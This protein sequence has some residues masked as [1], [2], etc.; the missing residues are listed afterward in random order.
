MEIIPP[1]TVTDAIFYSSSISEPSGFDIA[2]DHY[3]GEWSAGTNYAVDDMVMVVADHRLY[4]SLITPNEGFTPGGTGNDAY[5]LIFGATEAWLPFDKQVTGQAEAVGGADIVYRFTPGMSIDSVVLLNI[6]AE[7]VMVERRHGT[8]A[9]DVADETWNADTYDEVNE[10]Y[11]SDIVKTDFGA[12]NNPY[13]TITIRNHLTAAKVGEIVIGNK[14]SIG[15]TLYTPT[16]GIIDYSVKEIDS[17]GNYTITERAYSKRLTCTTRVQNTALDL[18]YNILAGRRALP[19]VW[20][21]S[22]D[23]PSMIVYGFYKDFSIVLSYK[24][25]SICELEIEGLV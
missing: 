20:V 19:T 5:W 8:F 13:F 22:V 10:L 3:Q 18:T 6:E 21:G 9:G 11:V 25:I 14:E 17:F 7:S 1:I 16:I 2:Q 15:D 4:V 23:Y 24:T 12:D